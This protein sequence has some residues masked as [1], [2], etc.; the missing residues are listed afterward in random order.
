MILTG[1]CETPLQSID[2]KWELTPCSLKVALNRK[3]LRRRRRFHTC[4]NLLFESSP[5][6]EGIK[7][8]ATGGT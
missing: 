5:E 6:S 3:G 1:S 2:S 8:A 4:N 7:T